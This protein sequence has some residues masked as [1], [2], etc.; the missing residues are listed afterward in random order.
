[1]TRI[2]TLLMLISG[3]SMN[4]SAQVLT[5]DSCRNMAERNNRQIAIGRVQKDIA[6]NVRKSART[7]YLPRVTALGGYELTSREISILSNSQQNVLNNIG[8][9]A[10]GT[11]SGMLTQDITALVQ[12]GVITP[13]AAQ[14]IQ[15]QMGSKG[16]QL[17]QMGNAVGQKITEAFH[18]DTKQIFAASVMLTQP[19]YMGGT[20]TA[21]NRM[22]DIQESMAD[23]NFDKQ[24][25][26]TRYKVDNTYWLVVSLS[27]KLALAKQYN[28][29]LKQLNKDVA[30]MIREGVATKADGLKVAVKLNES[31][32]SL[33]QAENGISLAKM[34]LC[35][36]CG[37]DL[38]SQFSLVDESSSDVSLTSSEVGNIDTETAIEQRP[39]IRL[40]EN[41]VELSS[42]ATKMARATNL[43][44][45]MLTGGYLVTNPNVYD[46]FS[47][48]F[49]GIWSVGVMVRVPVWNWFDGAYKVRAAKGATVMANYQLAEAREGVELQINQSRYKLQESLKR[50]K[51][52]KS[53]I[54]SAE[55]N[56][57]CANLGF[58]EGVISSTDVLGA[59]TAWFEAKSQSIDADIDVRMNRLALEKAMGV[60]M[61]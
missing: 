4:V 26:E 22:A 18:T 8:T 20:I 56:L 10:M 19:L 29:L 40:L 44:Q 46:G 31:E 9:T 33:T 51:M 17:S 5:L 59:Q 49:A 57:R 50:Q 52:A 13:Q 16:E 1:M 21:M 54:A 48:S 61:R 3:C 42:Q 14:A 2:I 37:M 60:I 27:H 6:K 32:V 23:N 28:E 7:K 34:L 43:P 39:E 58:R 47:R 55:E 12:Q 24:L 53:N 41:V 30:N 35:Q 15:Q 25:H 45:V 36:Q 38:D 11:L